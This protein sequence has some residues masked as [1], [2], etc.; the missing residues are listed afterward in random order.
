MMMILMVVAAVYCVICGIVVAAVGLT[1][2]YKEH[3]KK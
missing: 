1:I 3:V 2:L